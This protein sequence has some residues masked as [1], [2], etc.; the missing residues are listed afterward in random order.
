[1]RQEAVETVMRVLGSFNPSGKPNS[2]GTWMAVSC[3]LAPWTHKGRDEHPSMMVNIEPGRSVCHCMGCGFS[4]GAL[5]LAKEIHR[6]GGIDDETLKELTYL[7]TLEETKHWAQLERD[8]P[9]IPESLVADLDQWH[10]YW[11]QRGVSHE[12]VR[13]WRLGYSAEQKRVLIPFFDFEGSLHGVV[14]RDITGLRKDKYRVFPTGFDRSR[15]VFGEHLITGG[16]RSLLVVEGYLDA[17]AARRYLPSDMGVVAL[18]T[19]RPSNDQVRKIALFA[20]EEVISALDKDDTGLIGAAKLE[21]LLRG[22]VKMTTIDY[23]GYK[24][25]D[26]A[27]E[28]LPGI[29]AKRRGGM[30]DDVVSRLTAIAGA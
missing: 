21:R 23:G 2:E 20:N 22:R 28:A 15:Y 12:E 16:E 14:G 1:M 10:P 24:D 3:P 7:I 8:K 19:A 25:A 26:E 18:G 30:F 27:G 6:Y 13:R 5:G 11:E 9:D 4:S 17:I 29:L